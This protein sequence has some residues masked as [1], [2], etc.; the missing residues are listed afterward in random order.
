M[1][2]KEESTFLKWYMNRLIFRYK[3]P[4]DQNFKRF[5]SLTYK[6]NTDKN[7]VIAPQDL[8]KI[9]SKYYAD[10]FLDKSENMG[11]T[12]EERTKLRQFIVSITTD[13]INNRVPSELIINT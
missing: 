11:Y 3:V 13:I 7:I 9:I 4:L 12:E 8:D 6:A 10:F 1:F 5:Y 2:D